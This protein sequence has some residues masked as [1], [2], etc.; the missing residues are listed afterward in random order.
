MLEDLPGQEKPE[1][2]L[3]KTISR[4]ILMR[5]PCELDQWLSYIFLSSITW[6]FKKLRFRKFFMWWGLLNESHEHK[7]KKN[8]IPWESSMVES[9]TTHH[10]SSCLHLLKYYQICD[11]Q[12]FLEFW[13][14]A[15]FCENQ[16]QGWERLS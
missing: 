1:L 5:Q 14:R 15:S 9:N 10:G 7:D 2:E 12:N 4:D 8:K 6:D 13:I 11:L 16:V 3:W